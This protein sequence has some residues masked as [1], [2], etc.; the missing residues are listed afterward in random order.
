MAIDCSIQKYFP[1]LTNDQID[2]FAAM[3]LLYRYWN[4]RVNLISR[5]DIEG[6]YMHHVLHSLAIAKWGG[7]KPGDHV[8]DLGTGGGFP[9]I[10]LAVY[11]PQINFK[12]IDGTRKKIEAVNAIVAE[13]KL[14]NVAA[15]HAR[16]E[17]L[18]EK[19]DHIIVRAVADLS[20]LI[21]WC[22][23][24]LTSPKSKIVLLKGGDLR[25]ELQAHT[26]DF[27]IEQIS[28]TSYFEEHYYDQKYLLIINQNQTV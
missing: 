23:P 15:Q 20:K 8:L 14:S 25:K 5:K 28:L 1:D 4:E 3:D 9:G 26:H 21:R 27:T 13:L 2:Q 22:R 18:S 17:S 16:A 10:P 7:L 6:L 11:Y 12:L 24:L 19:F